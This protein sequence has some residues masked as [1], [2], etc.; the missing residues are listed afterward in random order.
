MPHSPTMFDVVS[1][2]TFHL[3][4]LLSYER[5]GEERT[6]ENVCV[7]EREG[8][9]ELRERERELRDIV[10]ETDKQSNRIGVRQ[11]DSGRNRMRDI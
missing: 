2:S 10:T 11:R 6:R 8:E 3:V 7:K 5:E 9:R 1:R 4:S